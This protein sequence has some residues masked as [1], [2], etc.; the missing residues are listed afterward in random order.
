M[1]K[2]NKLLDIFKADCTRGCGVV[3]LRSRGIAFEVPG[4]GMAFEMGYGEMIDVSEI[5]DETFAIYYLEEDE[6]CK[7]EFESKEA[8]AMLEKILQYSANF[9]P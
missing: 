5:T 2:E 7:I 8:K 3:Y 9:T 4:K 1:S 6:L